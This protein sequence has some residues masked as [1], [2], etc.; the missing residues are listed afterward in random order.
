MSLEV[1]TEMAANVFASEGPEDHSIEV[2]V[3]FLL[4]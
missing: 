4:P 1:I 3:D 2:H